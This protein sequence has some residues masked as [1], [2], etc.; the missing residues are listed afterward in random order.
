MFKPLVLHGDRGGCVCLCYSGDHELDLK[1]A[2][3]A[4][5]NKLDLI[6][7]KGIAPLPGTFGEVARL[8]G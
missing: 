2:A 8:S 7:M 6:P 1:V 3:K 5:R 4:S